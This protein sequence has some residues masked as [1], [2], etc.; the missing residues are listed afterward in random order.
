MGGSTTSVERLAEKA[1]EEEAEK[2][3]K[4]GKSDEDMTG[5]E[6]DG[7]DDEEETKGEGEGG[8]EEGDVEAGNVTPFIDVE[9]E[10]EKE[11]EELFRHVTGGGDEEMGGEEEEKEKE[12]ERDTGGTGGHSTIVMHFVPPGQEEKVRR[13]TTGSAVGSIRRFLRWGERWLSCS[14]P[15]TTFKQV[16]LPFDIPEDSRAFTG[17]SLVRLSSVP[18]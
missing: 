6:D 17:G 8:N 4:E 16:F 11:R 13:F 5:D 18:R 2:K 10:D 3:A 1:E 7:E 12:R 15:C 9:T 14:F